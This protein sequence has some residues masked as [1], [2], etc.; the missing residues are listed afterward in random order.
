MTEYNLFRWQ[1]GKWRFRI[2][3]SPAG[4][5]VITLFVIFILFIGAV[6]S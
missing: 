4:M 5:I 1:F 2:S 3:I 6:L